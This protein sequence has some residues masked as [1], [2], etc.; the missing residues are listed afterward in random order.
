MGITSALI[1]I[2]IIIVV[3]YKKKAAAAAMGATS[4]DA[5]Q[6]EL[7]DSRNDMK[8]NQKQWGIAQA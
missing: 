2:I 6:V 4:A 7:Q 3:V 5:N 8:F 1:I